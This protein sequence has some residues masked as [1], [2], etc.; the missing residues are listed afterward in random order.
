MRKILKHG[1]KKEIK[2]NARW[3]T[4]I[5]NDFYCSKCGAYAG[6]WY[7]GSTRY[8]SL[9][10]YCGQCGAKMENNEDSEVKE[11]GQRKHI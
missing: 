5:D 7:R 3:L 6:Y 10:N 9:T 8:Q 1:K 4:G 11:N 2:E